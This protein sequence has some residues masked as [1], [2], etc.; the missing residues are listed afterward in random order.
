MSDL[1]DNADRL[2]V[3]SRS[4]QEAQAEAFG[5]VQVGIGQLYAL[6]TDPD[7]PD[8]RIL[9]ALIGERP[10]LR[11]DF[12]ALQRDLALFS[13]P[14][15]AAAATDDRLSERAFPG[16]RI[17]LVP[18]RR[19]GQVY[20]TIAFDDPV[21]AGPLMLIASAPDGSLQR[22]ALPAADPEGAVFTVLDP[23]APDDAG[24]I[25]ALQSPKGSATLLPAREAPG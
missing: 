13:L 12:M 11:R 6:L 21:P 1:F 22:R 8:A 15:Q 10:R 18:A 23:S 14:Q 4:L 20:L 16:G 2:F 3:A 7:L 9:L 17:S 19:G 24:L 5:Q 25:A